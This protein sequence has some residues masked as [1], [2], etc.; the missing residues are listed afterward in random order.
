MKL[1]RSLFASVM[2]FAVACGDSVSDA[3]DSGGAPAACNPLAGGACMLPF[4]SSV[5][6]DEDATSATGFR[7]NFPAAAM[8]VN[9]DGRVVDTTLLNRYDGFSPNAVIVVAFATGVSSDGLPG[10]RDITQSMAPGAGVVLLDMESGERVPLFAEVDANEGISDDAPEKRSLLIRPLQRMRPGKRY[11]VAIRRTVLAADGS[12]LAIPPAFQALLDGADFDHPLFARLAARAPDIFAALETHGIP[13]TELALAWDFVTASDEFLTSD[14]LT[15]R[16]KALP[17]MPDDGAGMT[18][19]AAEV[20]GLGNPAYVHRFIRG[21]YDVPSFL[22]NGITDASHMQRGADGLPELNGT[23]P[24]KFAAIVPA[25]AVG[26]GPVPVLVFGHGLF[27]N[28][29]GYLDSEFLQRVVNDNCVVCV[30]GDFIGLSKNDFATAAFAV[31]DINKFPNLIDKLGQGVINFMAL[32]R[33]VRG[34][35]AQSP[36]FQIDGEVTIDPTKVYYYGASLGGI[37]GNVFMAY[38]PKVFKGALGV[39]GGNWTLNFERSLAWPPLQI[40]L[41]AA[42]PGFVL[43]QE[44]IALVGMLWDRFDPITTTARVVLDPLPDTPS[45]QIFMYEALNDSLVTPLSTEMVAR[46]MGIPVTGPS[47]YV[48]FG[49]TEATDAV[50][51][52]LT[53][54]DEHATPA[55]LETNVAPFEDSGTHSNVNERNAVQR[56]VRRF[57]EEGMVVHGCAV[58]GVPAPCDCATGACD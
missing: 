51:S 49:M 25:C 42:Y 12:A 14:L 52:G 44:L 31:N 15:M 18:F 3:P 46:T 43:D 36:L 26:R 20:A 4:P 1:A 57:F 32:S 24:A 9:I 21:T 53:I 54:F 45:K 47:L 6:L 48:P 8:P 2:L 33:V 27:G 56:M 29:F 39:P 16:T 34:P 10:H 7:V 38:E 11:A 41:Q 37:M 35:M 28:G 40:A 30:A 5:Y 58:A 13:K 22:T 23:I 50:P 17:D 55:P 19:E